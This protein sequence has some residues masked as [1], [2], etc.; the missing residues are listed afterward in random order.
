[1][2][3]LNRDFPSGDPSMQSM[4]TGQLLQ[5]IGL[6]LSSSQTGP[7]ELLTTACGIEHEVQL[8]VLRSDDRHYHCFLRLK[9]S[10]AQRVCVMEAVQMR[11]S[12]AS[13]FNSIYHISLPRN[14]KR[15]YP[16]GVSNLSETAIIESLSL[17]CIFADGW[18]GANF[19]LT[20]ERPDAIRRK[21]W[22][23]E[24]KAAC[25]Q[26]AAAIFKTEKKRDAPMTCQMLIPSAAE[27]ADDGQSQGSSMDLL[28]R[29]LKSSGLRDNDEDWGQSP[30][31]INHDEEDGTGVESLTMVNPQWNGE[32]EMYQL[33]YA[34]RAQMASN[35]NMQIANV[36]ATYRAAFQFGKLRQN[37]FN[38]DFSDQLCPFQAFAF[39]LAIL[40]HSSVGRK[41]PNL[42]MLEVC[43]SRRRAGRCLLLLM[44]ILF[45]LAWIA[46]GHTLSGDGCDAGDAWWAISVGCVTLLSLVCTIAAMRQALPESRGCLTCLAF[47]ILLSLITCLIMLSNITLEDDLAL[48]ANDTVN[49]SVEMGSG[50]MG[51]GSGETM[52]RLLNEDGSTPSISLCPHERRLGTSWV[53]WLILLV[54]LASCASISL[55]IGARRS[56]TSSEHRD[57]RVVRRLNPDGVPVDRD[58]LPV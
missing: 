35:K 1:M 30:T 19:V 10:S 45:T 31:V 28:D 32:N 24:R 4:P 33:T 11:G 48:V 40:D 20:D 42:T 21:K 52:L 14:D 26:H 7:K 36:K 47:L 53:A 51:S 16:E 56:V 27:E 13:A 15:L 50:E 46:A 9:N 3:L 37:L 25:K 23:A 43:A 6:E 41:E 5:Q 54:I 2:P 58:G 22:G 18:N 44:L 57:E 17:G 55:C 39:A 8:D 38:V 34:S 29:L 49:A 12:A